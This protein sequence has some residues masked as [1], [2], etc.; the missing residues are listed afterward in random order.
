[1]IAAQML[2]R[3]DVALESGVQARI[4]GIGKSFAKTIALASVSLDF[5]AGEVHAI[6]GENGAGKTTLVR[7]LSGI[8]KPD[9][10]HL[11]ISGKKVVLSGRKD[12]AA[13][14][15]GIVQQQDG[16]IHELS[17]VENYLI[18]H[19]K[20]SLWLDRSRAR[21]ELIKTAQKLGLTVRPDALI[22]ELTIGERQRL[23]ILIALMIGAQ[24]IILDEP[25]AALLTNEVQVLIPV[26][27]RLVEQGRSVVYITHK[28]DEV[29]QIA[30]RVTVLRR[31]QV[32][33]RFDRSD[34]DKAT[35]IK[36]M[37]GRVPEKLE[38]ALRELGETI[39]ELNG[40]SVPSSRARRGLNAVSLSVRR[41]EIL[42]VAGVV[43]N[44]QEALAELLRGLAAPNE[45]E[46]RLPRRV[47]F[48]PEDRARDALAMSLSIA[49]NSIIYRHREPQFRTASRLN[50][51]AV[52][53]FVQGLIERAGIIAGSVSAPASSLSG[54]NQQKLVIA[55][56]FDRDPDLIVAHNPYRGL[57]VA[58]TE[59]VRRSLLKARERGAAVVLISP[60]IDDLFDISNRIVFLSNGR[61]SGSVEPRSTTV[62]ALGTLLGGA[63]L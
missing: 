32:V 46:L 52:T 49:D 10:G 21:D 43:G 22:G 28:L 33:G 47:A 3:A 18:D 34:L 1:M 38:P 8:L 6:L 63:S 20:A 24:I 19:P 11:E 16:L 50:M 39:V 59:T 58:A 17:G 54:G 15:V 35:L 53:E 29:M 45:G 14:G 61:I 12:G 26:I 7:I 30:D 48:I 41:H 57:D 60:D 56:E 42:G 9:T 4:V 62:Q 44:G 23:E 36:A 37:V 27:R 40:V 25:T 51:H 2:Q 55:R 5:R 31:G 13:K